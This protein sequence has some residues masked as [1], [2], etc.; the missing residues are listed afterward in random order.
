MLLATAGPTG[1]AGSDATNRAPPA[2]RGRCATL[3]FA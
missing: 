3:H 2:L 1:T